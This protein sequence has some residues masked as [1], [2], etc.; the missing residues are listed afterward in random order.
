MKNAIVRA[1]LLG[2]VVSLVFGS[3]SAVQAAGKGE[4]GP[5]VPIRVELNDRQAD[6]DV[7]KKMDLDVD[8]VFENWARIYV[9][10][11][12]RKKLTRLG[13]RI[14]EMP[15][16]LPGFHDTGPIP[17]AE[18][19]T[20]RAIP[21]VYHT[22]AT[23]TAELQAIAT[24]RPDLVRLTSIGQSAEPLATPR[25]LWM[26]KISR[27]PDLDEDEP[28]V[29]YI[30]AMH[31][32]E[33]VG[34]ELCIEFIHYLLDN[35]GTDSRVTDLV[36]NT[37]IWIMPS[38]NPDGTE[39]GGRYNDNGYDLNRDFP[40]WFQDPVNSTDG[41]QPETVA[42]MN[43][44]NQHNIN[45]SA[46]F[47]GGALVAN[48]PFDGNLSG[49]SVFTPSPDPDHPMF[50]SISLT[51]SSNNPPM[52][53]SFSFADGITNG[54]DWYWIQGGMQD[55]NYVWAGNYQLTL[56]VSDVK[57]PS[58]NQLPT[59][60]NENRESMLSFLERAHEGVRG[61]VTDAV[62]GEPVRAE[63]RLDSDQ[64][65]AYTDANMGDYHRLVLPGSYSMEV[66]ASGYQAQTIPITVAAGS[67]VR[68]D[69]VLQPLASDLQPVG[70][71]VEDGVAGN[72][73]LDAGETTDVALTLKNLGAAVTGVN[74]RLISTSW[75]ADVSRA[76][77][78]YPDLSNQ[79]AGESDAPYHEVVVHSDVPTGHKVG[80]AVEWEAAEGSGT[81]EPI[82]L[83][84]GVPL[85]SDVDA[86]GLPQG[87]FD[88]QTTTS[89]MTIPSGPDVGTIEVTVDIS[90]TYIGD[91]IVKLISPSATEVLLHNGSGGT[92]EDIVGTYGVNLTAA[93]S[94]ADFAGEPSTGTWTLE[95]SDEAGGDTGSLN[96]WSLDICG[97]QLEGVPPQ[98]LL[99]SVDVEPDGTMLRW[100][101]YPGL[102]SYRVYRST[103]A[104]SAPAFIDVTG[105]DG[106]ATDTS[107]K[108]T[109]SDSLVFFLVTGV[110]SQG[111][112]PKGHF[113]E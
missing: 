71:R 33:V 73:Y 47:H 46:N 20:Q 51:Y 43:W 13:Y 34:K 7:F 88:N 14:S 12:E 111:E 38:M 21:T 68:H 17:A 65:P 23:L 5:V 93:G 112:G 66:S 30:A 92:S 98:L 102:S 18:P 78:T 40:D 106:D 84:V 97:A 82:F 2:L 19:G 104:D 63:I 64:F 10:P 57:W 11:K 16:E 75:Y 48:Y 105:E 25:E 90:H 109:S 42:L 60:W 96:A 83:D 9:V 61:L 55:W 52:Y 35:Y 59:F 74:G 108:D 24:A 91:L 4:P 31:G 80:L 8:G 77:T 58:G 85:C 62:T 94:L 100:W 50:V 79:Q 22:Y 56:E 113:G 36:D 86:T 107:F 44:G 67:A 3:T 87:I 29:A 69:V 37:V 28:E 95:I 1:L 101:P 6:L 70:S 72:G 27:N 26:M 89:P 15:D 39:A 45:L 99:R 76:E 110:G 54:A 41:R 49:S 81:S 32:D 53:S 103:Q